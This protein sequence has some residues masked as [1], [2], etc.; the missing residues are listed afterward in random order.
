MKTLVLFTSHF[1]YGTGETFLE[2][3]IPALCRSFD[4]VCICTELHPR[5]TSARLLPENCSVVRY[6]TVSRFSDA[7]LQIPLFLRYFKGCREALRDERRLIPSYG[8]RLTRAHLHR[9]LHDLM[10]GLQMARA[11]RKRFTP[12]D[13]LFY[14]YWL[15]APAMGLALL[16]SADSRW[17]AVSRMHGHDV[18]AEVHDPAYIPFQLFKA[19]HLCGIY[20]ISQQGT[21]YLAARLPEAAGKLHTAYLGTPDP[22]PITYQDNGSGRPLHIVTCSN[23]PFTDVKRIPLLIEAL[24][25]V[26]MPLHWTHLGNGPQIAYCLTRAESLHKTNPQ[27]TFT[28]EGQ[29]SNKGVHQFYATHPVDAVLNVSSSEGLP[30]ALMEAASYG[31]P[32]LATDVG[33]TREVCTDR[34]GRLLPAGITP[35]QLASSITEFL[36]VTAPAMDRAGI[37]EAWAATFRAAS[38]FPEWAAML[39]QMLRNDN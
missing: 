39:E 9:M 26:R 36:T 32:L 21:D 33:G 14:T 37:R 35:E 4:H 25:H 2:P 12:E 1:P 29:L 19:R 5:E 38:N 23:L 31:I 13:T 15:K 30:V 10:K 17:K 8:Q 3:E 20:G 11:I 24:H 6:R 16:H 18:Y 34:T 27:I 22:L 28:F 7:L